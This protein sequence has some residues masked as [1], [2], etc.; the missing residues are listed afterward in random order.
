[1]P[2]RKLTPDDVYAIRNKYAK[3]RTEVTALADKYGVTRQCIYDVLYG[4]TF[5][6]VGGPRVATTFG[7]IDSLSK[8]EVDTC[9]AAIAAGVLPSLRQAAKAYGVSAPTL[10]KY[11]GKYGYDIHDLKAQQE[12]NQ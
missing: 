5:K 10:S 4:R 6:W 3:G 12:A 1:M 8:K 9:A 11:L 7:H 2:R